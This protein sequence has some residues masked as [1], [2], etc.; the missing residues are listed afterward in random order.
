[1]SHSYDKALEMVASGKVDVNPLVTHRY[2]LEESL[3]AFQR[4]KTGDGGAIKVTVVKLW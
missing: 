3:E 2:K 1:V 4:A